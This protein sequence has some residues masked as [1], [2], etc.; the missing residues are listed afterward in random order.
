MSQYDVRL[1]GEP[2]SS[3]AREVINYHTMQYVMTPKEV[4]YLRSACLATR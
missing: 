1:S 3:L 2:C 4:N